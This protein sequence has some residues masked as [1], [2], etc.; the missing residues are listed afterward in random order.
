MP[1]LDLPL[2]ELQSYSPALPEPEDFDA[3]WADTLAQSRAAGGEV[4]VTPI[5]TPLETIEAFDVTFPGFAG[6]P[7][8]AWLLLPA[9][10]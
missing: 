4:V 1:R 9:G 6:D 2:A 7:V 3:F 10:R 8:K 5:D